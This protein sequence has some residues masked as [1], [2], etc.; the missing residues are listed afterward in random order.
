MVRTCCYQPLLRCAAAAQHGVNPECLLQCS[1][2]QCVYC[3]S[4][5]HFA[6]VS[7]TGTRRSRRSR[8]S[9]VR[10]G[11]PLGDS[12]IESQLRL[13]HQ[14]GA[15]YVAP[16]PPPPPPTT[17][18]N[19]LVYPSELVCV[20]LCLSISNSII[21]T[22]QLEQTLVGVLSGSSLAVQW[23]HFWRQTRHI[24]RTRPTAT[25]TMV[26]QRWRRSS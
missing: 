15:W 23:K 7:G 22:L 18:C 5:P 12:K 21:V 16:L 13:R 3:I 1:M 17:R 2:C 8:G 20:I 10:A 26:A 25:R 4:V 11:A 14:A 24:W 9:G 19:C 6:F